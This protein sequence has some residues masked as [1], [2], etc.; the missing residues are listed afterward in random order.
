MN[1]FPLKVDGSGGNQDFLEDFR[2]DVV[3]KTS[4]E[5]GYLKFR[6]GGK[7]PSL[8]QLEHVPCGCLGAEHVEL[9]FN[10]WDLGLVCL[11]VFSP[12]SFSYRGSYFQ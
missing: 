8:L 2:V 6:L 7:V 9:Q 4:T 1:F 11:E 12:D 3:S 5:V 10:S